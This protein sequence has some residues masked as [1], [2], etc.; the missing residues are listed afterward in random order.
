M[1]SAVLDTLKDIAEDISAVLD[2]PVYAEVPQV[3]LDDAESAL[4]D[5]E[6]AALMYYSAQCM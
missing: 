3:T 1:I 6:Y 4:L 5:A 2:A